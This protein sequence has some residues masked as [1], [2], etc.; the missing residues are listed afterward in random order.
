[1]PLVWID[2]IRTF[3]KNINVVTAKKQVISHEMKDKLAD[4][5][6]DDLK[7][8]ESLLGRKLWDLSK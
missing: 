6:K 8:L 5:F 7:S 1:M 4:V 2:K 3:M